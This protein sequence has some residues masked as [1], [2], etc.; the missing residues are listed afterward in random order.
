MVEKV[1]VVTESIVGTM[2]EGTMVEV[3]GT[4]IE[5]AGTM[6]ELVVTESV[7]MRSC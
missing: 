7:V 6:V 3:V 2:V 4:I 5:V 1:V